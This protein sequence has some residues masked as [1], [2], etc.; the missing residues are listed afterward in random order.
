MSW[1]IDLV[2]ISDAEK[3]LLPDMVPDILV[4]HVD[5]IGFEDATSV[6]RYDPPQLCAT[7]HATWGVVIDVP[8]KLRSFPGHMAEQSRGRELHLIHVA[9]RPSLLSYADGTQTQAHEGLEAV[10]TRLLAAPHSCADLDDGEL[11]AWSLA[12]QTVGENLID[13]LWEKKFA[14]FALEGA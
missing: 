1:N 6:S 14:I 9:M 3:L 11:V 10:R 2:L 12:S 5:L 4:G 13:A 8:C 7:K